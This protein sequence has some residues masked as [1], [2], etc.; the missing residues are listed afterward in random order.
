MYCTCTCITNV[1]PRSCFGKFS[2]DGGWSAWSD[3]GTC[4]LECGGGQQQQGRECSNPYKVGDGLD[5]EGDAVR[6]LDCN[7]HGCKGTC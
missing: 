1:M 4:S 6:Y 7:T 2:V 3:V 5:C